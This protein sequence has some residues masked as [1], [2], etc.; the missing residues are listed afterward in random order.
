MKSIEKENH[1]NLTVSLGGEYCLLCFLR[2][3]ILKED[4]RSAVAVEILEE[5][6]RSSEISGV[7]PHLLVCSR[8][9]KYDQLFKHDT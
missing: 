8:T 5:F 7:M 3:R 9:F 1:E 4:G 2:Y 6:R